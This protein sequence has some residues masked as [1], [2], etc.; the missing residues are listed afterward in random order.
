MLPLA[1]VLVGCFSGAAPALTSLESG[2]TQ[3]TS[4]SSNT[5]ATNQGSEPEWKPVET[6]VLEWDTILNEYQLKP[7]LGYGDFSDYESNFLIDRVQLT[8]ATILCIREQG[9]PV[10]GG[11]G[12]INFRPIP[13]EQRGLAYATSIACKVGL[14]AP[15]AQPLTPQQLKLIYDYKIALAGCYSNAGYTQAGEIV[16][17]DVFVQSEGGWDLQSIYDIP[18]GGSDWDALER[19]C[20][21]SPV[22]G[23]GAWAPGEPVQPMP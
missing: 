23:W 19:V 2:P 14:G 12:S 5:S 1:I 16:S 15:I 22:G 11:N 10:S 18:P 8:A 6:G 20:P 3:T 21:Q 9:F 17:L 7:I 13:E 4:V